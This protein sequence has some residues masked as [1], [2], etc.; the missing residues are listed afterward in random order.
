VRKATVGAARRLW[1]IGVCL[2]G[3]PALA[4]C[5]G[6]GS[7]HPGAIA[8][9]AST[10]VW[11]S[12][13]Q[14]VAGS[15]V[16]VKSILT[17][18]DTDPHSYQ[19]SPSDAAAITDAA[20]VVYNGGGYDSWVDQVLAWHPAVASVDAYALLAVPGSAGKPPNE[21]VFYNLTVAKSVAFAIA[22]RLAGLDPR[23]GAEYRSN[24]DEFG[25]SADAIA[26]SEH[27]IASKYHAK[28]VIATEPV[29]GYL[30]E[31]AGLIN[32]TPP[33]FAA[34]TENETDPSPTDMASVLDLVNYHQVAVLLINPQTSTTAIG[35]LRA[36]ARRAGVPVTE[37]TE[38]LPTG[39][40]YLTWQRNTVN[41]LSAALQTST[42][43]P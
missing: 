4:A 30:L 41:Q 15:H 33:A 29:G 36:A 25:R 35:S 24:A 23:N 17:G 31:A 38:T 21:H 42:H 20:L 13:A 37:V 6:T 12:V 32:R 26:T 27:A 2:I 34:A 39:T 5:G 10:D 16:A 18:L 8:V 9:V 11:G 7:A 43:L 40:D 1:A 28:S 19:A 3:S 14:A 22:D